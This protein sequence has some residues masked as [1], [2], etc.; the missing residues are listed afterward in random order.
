MNYKCCPNCGTKKIYDNIIELYEVSDV[1]AIWT[2]SQCGTKERISNDE[3]I[4]RC[5][6]TSKSSSLR[7]DIISV[8]I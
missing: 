5:Q 6:A 4:I 3:L 7:T 1:Y 2:C 8:E